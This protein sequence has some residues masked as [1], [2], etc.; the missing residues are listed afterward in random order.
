MTPWTLPTDV[1][2][3]AEFG[4]ENYDISWDTINNFQEITA[5]DQQYIKTNKDL[6]HIA[7]SPK[8]DITMKTWYLRCTGFNFI[9]LPDIITGIELRLIGNRR[10]RITDETVQLCLEEEAIGKNQ[11]NLDLSPKKL[12]GSDND[13]WETQLTILNLQDPTFGALI[14][15]Q[16]HPRWP[17]KDSAFLDAVELRI[18]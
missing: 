12:Y 11:A 16:S 10:G 6:L 1:V 2:Q 8:L 13:L 9:N 3:Y 4:A 17:H 18:H 14:R 5:V 15:F 7:R